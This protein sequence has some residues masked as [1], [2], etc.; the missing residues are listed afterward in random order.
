[1]KGSNAE[2]TSNEREAEKKCIKCILQTT[3]S[4]SALDLAGL[5]VIASSLQAWSEMTNRKGNF[6]FLAEK[7]KNWI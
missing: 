2:K 6:G 7:L 3:G 5:L 4:Q 1:M